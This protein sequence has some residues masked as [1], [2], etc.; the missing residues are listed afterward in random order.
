ML[1]GWSVGPLVGPSVCP[2]ITLKTDYVA[3]ALRLG[4]GNNLVCMWSYSFPFYGSRDSDSLEPSRAFKRC[5]LVSEA[6]GKG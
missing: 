2:H 1:V 4:F 5:S 3:I 6:Y